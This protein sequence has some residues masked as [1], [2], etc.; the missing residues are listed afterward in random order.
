MRFANINYCS[1]NPHSATLAHRN[2]LLFIKTVPC[3]KKQP[4]SGF[5]NFRTT[6]LLIKFFLTSLVNLLP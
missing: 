4:T 3:K 2:K 6:A 5:E 1:E